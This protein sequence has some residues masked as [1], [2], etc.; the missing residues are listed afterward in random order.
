MVAVAV[1]DVAGEDG[2]DHKRAGEA[3]GADA[4]VEDAVV[5]PVFES[6]VDGFGE[7]RSR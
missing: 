1:G 4:I 5:A 2:G 3:D 6:F 7:S